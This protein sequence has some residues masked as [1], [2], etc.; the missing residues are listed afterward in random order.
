MGSVGCRGDC[1]SHREVPGSRWSALE[2]KKI[3]KKNQTFTCSLFILLNSL[4]LYNVEAGGFFF[5]FFF[6]EKNEHHPMVQHLSSLLCVGWLI[7]D[8]SWGADLTTESDIP[9]RG[10]AGWYSS[11][12]NKRLIRSQRDDQWPVSWALFLSPSPSPLRHLFP[13]AVECRLILHRSHKRP[14]QFPERAADA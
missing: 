6:F 4:T 2:E 14:L 5:F 10:S 8:T 11:L 7:G 9:V 13:L 12:S 3:T 1:P